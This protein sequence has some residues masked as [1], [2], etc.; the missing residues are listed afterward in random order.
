MS[1]GMR[2][3]WSNEWGKQRTIPPRVLDHGKAIIMKTGWVVFYSKRVVAVRFRWLIGSPRC[4]DLYNFGSKD[5]LRLR[6]EE[7]NPGR[8]N[9]S[10]YRTFNARVGSAV[11][12]PIRIN[13]TP[14]FG[15]DITWK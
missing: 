13:T 3:Q 2:G 6:W 4:G 7:P 14:T 12:N 5:T 9:A 11:F 8:T 10:F 1:K 15:W